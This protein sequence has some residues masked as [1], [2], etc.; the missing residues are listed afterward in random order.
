MDIVSID[1]FNRLFCLRLKSAV[2]DHSPVN[3]FE[4]Q[5]YLILYLV[6]VVDRVLL[7]IIFFACSFCLKA[8]LS[9]FF[10]EFSRILL[11][12]SFFKIFEFYIKCSTR[13]LVDYPIR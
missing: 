11:V 1:G 10:G 8:E 2:C 13:S 12:I 9:L 3:T 6:L 7:V 4:L 5:Q